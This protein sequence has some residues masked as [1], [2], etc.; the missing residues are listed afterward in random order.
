ML[1]IECPWCG[2]REET[3][4]SCG[5]EAHIVRPPSPDTL[6]DAAELR[7]DLALCAPAEATGGRHQGDECGGD[8]GHGFTSKVLRCVDG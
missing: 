4:F 6:A 8:F 3:E 1:L 2:P 7:P 5:G